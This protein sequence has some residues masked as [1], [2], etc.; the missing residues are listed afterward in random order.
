[1]LRRRQFLRTAAGAVAGLACSR[2]GLD[3]AFAQSPG[4]AVSTGEA[5][6]ARRLGERSF[7]FTGAGG[8]VV[9]LDAPDQLV[10][11]DSGRPGRTSELLRAVA[12]LLGDDRVD[13]LINTHW[14]LEHSGG[15]DIIGRTASTIIAHEN[16]R[17]WMGTEFHVRWQD[18]TYPPRAPAALPNDTFYAHEPQPI[19]AAFGG[20]PAEYA[21]LPEAHTDGD[22]Y[23]FFPEDNVL[24]AGDAVSVGAYPVP[25]FSTGG[26]IGGLVDATQTLLGVA[27]ADTLIVPGIGPAVT[28]AHLEAQLEMLTTVRE[29]METD[30]RRGRSAAEILADG[31]TEEFDEAWGDPQLFV[32]NLYHGLWWV[33]RSGAAF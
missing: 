12:D 2:A 4:E 33:G 1:M 31:V 19:R 7:Q 27:D 16:T 23:V 13:T 10:M 3:A 26:W 6:R 22:I 5:V 15:N 24:V 9:V 8:N 11:V 29:R 30:M 20:I 25:D 14:H 28:R 18:R 21:H 32:N 17:L